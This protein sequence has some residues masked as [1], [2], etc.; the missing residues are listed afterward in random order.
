MNN[1]ASS[2]RGTRQL[3]KALP[4]F[5]ETLAK[6]QTMLGPDH[7]DTLTSMGNLGA[8]YTAG[9]Q[10]AEAVPLL[11]ATLAK[12]KARLGPDHPGTLVSMNDLAAA[13][14]ASGKLAQAIPLYEEC[15]VTRKAKYGLDHKMTRI[16]MVNL[17]KA[18]VE[19][20]QG[21]KAATTFAAMVDWSR[22]RAPKGSP[23]FAA[24]LAQVST[25]LMKCGQHAAAEPLLRECLAIRDKNEPDDWMTFDTQSMIG[26]ALMGQKE[27]AEAEPLLL[28]GYEGMKAREKSIPPQ[29]STRIPE[30][31]ERLIELYTATTKPE[32][33]KKYRELRAK[34]PENKPAQNR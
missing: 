30:A 3:A 18:C 15:L 10:L 27:Y 19:A 7:P 9:G 1:L 21:E 33:A 11:E 22:K 25:D 2:Y 31:L 16:A 4:L 28:K 12:Q 29:G 6:R 8:A 13:Y 32:D 24:L 17:G 34:Y 5:Q 23:T 14:E 20:K 26:A